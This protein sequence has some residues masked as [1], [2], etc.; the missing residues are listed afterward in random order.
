M[1]TLKPLFKYYKENNITPKMIKKALGI[2]KQRF[3]SLKQ[4]N[5]FTTDIIIKLLE[6][7]NYEV[8]FEECI[9]KDK[10]LVRDIRFLVLS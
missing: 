8:S 4:Q 9:M 7:A 6:L 10:M 2:S 3:Y 1:I 5:N